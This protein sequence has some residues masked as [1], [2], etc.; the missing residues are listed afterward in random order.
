MHLNSFDVVEL[1]NGLRCVVLDKTLN[2]VRIRVSNYS[3][4]LIYEGFRPVCR[5]CC[6][7]MKIWYSFEHKGIDLNS[8][9]TGN[10]NIKPDWERKD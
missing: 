5:V 2:K 8:V 3:E 7:I 9:Y 6:D 10:L 4:S 1:R